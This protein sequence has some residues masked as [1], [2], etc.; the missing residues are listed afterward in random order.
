MEDSDSVAADFSFM[1]DFFI[2]HG[3]SCEDLAA[4]ISEE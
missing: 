1:I 2:K 4:N 3:D